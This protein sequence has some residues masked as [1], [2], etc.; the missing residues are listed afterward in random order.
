[1]T[2]AIEPPLNEPLHPHAVHTHEYQSTGRGGAGNI[3]PRSASRAPN[4]KSP[5]IAHGIS[6]FFHRG[7]GSPSKQQEGGEEGAAAK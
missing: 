7:E 5:T 3:R 1:M 4:Q 6:A 2:T